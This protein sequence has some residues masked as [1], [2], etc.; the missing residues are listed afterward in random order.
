MSYAVSWSGGKDSML[1]LDRAVRRGLD[2]RWLFNLYDAASERVRFHAVRRELIARQAERL[3]LELVQLATRPDTFEARFVE[4][5]AR[6]AS[7]GATGV[8]YGN[9]HLDD[10]RAWYE[11]R[12][13]GRGLDH[14]EPLWGGHGADLLAELLER[15]YRTRLVSVDLTRG[16]PQWLGCELTVALAEELTARPGVDP[17]GEHGEYH[18]FVFDGPLFHAPLDVRAGEVREEGDHA[19]LDLEEQPDAVSL[20]EPPAPAE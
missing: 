14:L 13:A 9:I 7:L 12:T 5:L 3:G 4:G 19:V 2:V 8:I 15:G 11:E 18:T 17:S 1:A 20:P 16:R 10:V 6:L